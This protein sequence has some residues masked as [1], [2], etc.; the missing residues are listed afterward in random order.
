MIELL[1]LAAAPV[2]ALGGIAAWLDWYGGGDP[3]PRGADVVVVAGCRVL[4]DGRPSPA[5]ARRVDLAVGLIRDGV[6]P[7]L[8][9]TGGV[10]AGA[11]TSEAR[12]AADR[13]RAAGIPEAALLLEEASRDTLQNAA[14]AARVW[15][16]GGGR[17]AD[18]RVV[19]VT[20]RCHVF[21]CTRMF[22]AHFGRVAG[23]G[24]T[25]PADARVRSALREGVSV[26]H[27]GLRGRLGTAPL[28]WDR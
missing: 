5:L 2:G 9:L 18:A 11:P 13:A 20:D 17:A 14:F 21:R 3:G 23:A 12:C 1:A 25:P 8:L 15:E 16:A 7:R 22:A 28:G 10:G 27:H 26:V 24:A 6:A 19:V 4:P